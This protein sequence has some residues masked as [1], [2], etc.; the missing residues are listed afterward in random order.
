MA[1]PGR[2]LA[3]D[4]EMTFCLF[5]DK[6][7]DLTPD[8]AT[9]TYQLEYRRGTKINGKSERVRA[10][11]S[12]R[13]VAFNMNATI[14]CTL[15]PMANRRQFKPKPLSVHVVEVERNVTVIEIAVNLAEYVLD[16]RMTM[17][18][19]SALALVPPAALAFGIR[20]ETTARWNALNAAEQQR[21]ST[22]PESDEEDEEYEED[23]GSSASSNDDDV[24][25][26]APRDE[27]E[28]NSP[29]PRAGSQARV[30]APVDG[31]RT[32]AW[33]DR[34][35][36]TRRSASGRRLS[37]PGSRRT[38][39]ARPVT[40]VESVPVRA[41]AGPE[42]DDHA[43][44]F[45]PSGSREVAEEFTEEGYESMRVI[46]Q[47][48]S[49][50]ERSSRSLHAGVEASRAS[51][52]GYD[53]DDER[54]AAY[55]AASQGS[56]SPARGAYEEARRQEAEEER[57]A[58]ALKAE[59]QRREKEHKRRLEDIRREQDVRAAEESRMRSE[60]HKA[61]V[62]RASREL[63]TTVANLLREC[64]TS[65][66][67]A[68]RVDVDGV[69]SNIPRAAMRIVTPLLDFAQEFIDGRD[70]SRDAISG[71]VLPRGAGLLLLVH[72][73]IVMLRWDI[74]ATTQFD[75][76]QTGA[77]VHCLVL[78]LNALLQHYFSDDVKVTL[79]L[80]YNK[81][82]MAQMVQET[83]ESTEGAKRRG[84]GKWWRSLR[85][86]RKPV[87]GQSSEL[88]QTL[89]GRDR[90]MGCI[91]ECSSSFYVARTELDDMWRKH[92]AALE[93][94]P[95]DANSTAFPMLSALPTALFWN[96]PEGLPPAQKKLSNSPLW[97]MLNDLVHRTLNRNIAD[98]VSAESAV[99]SVFATLAI[100][101]DMALHELLIQC[102][103]THME[104]LGDLAFDALATPDAVML[105]ALINALDA[106]YDELMYTD[107][108]A[109]R[110]SAVARAHLWDNDLS[111]LVASDI[112]RLALEEVSNGVLN[113]NHRRLYDAEQEH[114]RSQR[115]AARR[116]KSNKK[117]QQQHVDPADAG[118]M[119]PVPRGPCELFILCTP[120][121]GLRLKQRL[122][123]LEEWLRGKGL[124]ECTYVAL[125]P[126][127]SLCDA[128]ILP[129]EAFLDATTRR[130]ALS[131]V[132]A[133]MLRAV[134]AALQPAPWED[135]YD[136]Q[137]GI[138]ARKELVANVYGDP[139]PYV[140]PATIVP[141]TADVDFSFLDLL[142][143]PSPFY[144]STEDIAVLLRDAEKA[145]RTRFEAA[146]VAKKK[147]S[148]LA[149]P[150]LD[151]CFVLV[152]PQFLDCGT[153]QRDTSVVQQFRGACITTL[154]DTTPYRRS[155]NI[156]PENVMAALLDEERTP[157]SFLPR[158]STLQP[159]HDV[160]NHGAAHARRKQVFIAVANAF[161][162]SAREG[163]VRYTSLVK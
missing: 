18:K 94:T 130:D 87:R 124:N 80:M 97:A 159:A 57:A 82:A 49:P 148:K 146:L 19:F 60:A 85:R 7:A 92:A 108:D 58:L 72:D 63:Q 70:S 153:S 45:R 74:A 78:L 47:V 50:Q 162:P 41:V 96:P 121:D 105:P 101:I 100:E 32:Y 5:F 104:P 23:F 139:A 39:V 135:E 109:D 90:A 144:G 145:E 83:R 76:R 4:V 156:D 11:R 69:R 81:V 46:P 116:A 161:R 123:T 33:R 31:E 21:L 127:R 142:A 120:D 118:I 151:H 16:E 163:H 3:G 149:E 10:D 67:A 37:E 44:A 93:T 95:G 12:R 24:F 102:V 143:T 119:V 42:R 14:R 17:H 38:S 158:S 113:Q 122:D 79:P 88:G 22:C 51:L 6:V 112:I 106:L 71:N 35:A 77:W 138:A 66:Q 131:S 53:T 26:G 62:T 91:S 30:R 73:L 13:E 54:N 27:D 155:I 86:P 129:S 15:Q 140:R 28:E 141:R 117:G 84:K 110:H 20:G 56:S 89:A 64:R 111:V 126:L 9:R 65:I 99:Q 8:Q 134:F 61:E 36:E 29:P 52:E 128:L 59:E 55:D 150:V 132:P 147:N 25:R 40:V 1:S 154:W 107:A 160:I 136:V 68:T 115:E 43:E 75:R 157:E 152:G 133:P 137:A 48:A 2:K 34:G 114:L 98:D 125:L 103:R